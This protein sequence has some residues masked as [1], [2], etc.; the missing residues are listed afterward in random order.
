MGLGGVVHGVCCGVDSNREEPLHIYG[1]P[2]IRRY[3]HTILQTTRPSLDLP[4]FVHELV[5]SDLLPSKPSNQRMRCARETSSYL[6]VCHVQITPCP[7]SLPTHSPWFVRCRDTDIPMDEAT[8][9]WNVYSDKKV[10][11]RCYGDRKRVA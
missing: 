6:L 4:V 2:G 7:S 5:Q 3:V 10:H 1:P 9:T 8:G 11:A